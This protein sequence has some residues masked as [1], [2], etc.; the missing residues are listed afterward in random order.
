[1]NSLAARLGIRRRPGIALIV[2][3]GALLA[4]MALAWAV[5]AGWLIDLDQTLL[6]AFRNAREPADPLGP[7]WLERVFAD[8]TS[9]GS[10]TVLGVVVLIVFGFLWLDGKHH[11]AL[12]VLLSA[13]SGVVLS[14]LLKDG[15]ERP[16]PEL[17]SRL[18]EVSSAS[19]PSGH[20]ML[21]A[22]I[23]LMLGVLIARVQM[24]P[25]LKIYPILVAIG[26]VASI[27]VSRLYLGVHWPTDV[28]A[29]WLVGAAWALLCYAVA[30]ALQQRGLVEGEP[31]R[32]SPAR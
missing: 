12:L 28:L 3:G 27:G 7:A 24:R 6:V 14:T 4:F 25:G 31:P 15:F 10:F 26:L 16:R 22:T 29:G 32:A 2:A 5:S 17:I 20:A 18:T 23:Y 30:G 8:L 9:L 19:F 21:S 1:M 11:A 13:A